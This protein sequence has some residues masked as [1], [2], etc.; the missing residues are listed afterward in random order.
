MGTA[1]SLAGLLWV[2]LLGRAGL[3]RPSD[4]ACALWADRHAD[5]ASAFSTWVEMRSGAHAAARAPALARLEQ[6]A[7]ARAPLTMRL[8]ETTR[9]PARLWPAL[10]VSLACGAFAALVFTLPGLGKSSPSASHASAVVE[11]EPPRAERKIA[12]ELAGEL[13]KSLRAGEPD[14]ASDRQAGS[15]SPLEVANSAD[16]TDSAA[17][18]SAAAPT[19]GGRAIDRQWPARAQPDTTASS[20]A[21]SASSAVSGREA[22]ESPDNGSDARSSRASA[23]GV[24]ARGGEPALRG[25]SSAKH[26]DMEQS[27]TFEEDDPRE[28]TTNAP[29]NDL[30]PVAAPP[31]LVDSA[32]MTPSQAA[33]VRAWMKAIEQRR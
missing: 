14:R 10:L 8:V 3:R 26:A 12:D 11:R 24:P 23:S 28:R 25:I 1:L 6:W 33:Y 22:G 2:S 16:R 7:S 19:P 15:P 9:D 20:G 4:G 5:G 29:G 18:R 27:A 30:A 13:T 31:P 21:A 32:R 17:T